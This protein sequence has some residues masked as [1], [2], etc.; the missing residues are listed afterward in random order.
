M[1]KYGVHI[2]YHPGVLVGAVSL[3]RI[4]LVSDEHERTSQLALFDKR[5]ESFLQVFLAEL[6][7]LPLLLRSFDFLWWDQHIVDDLDDSIRS[8]TIFNYD[9]GKTVDLDADEPTVASNINAKR[10]VFQQCRQINLILESVLRSSQK[11]LKDAYMEVALG[12]SGLFGVVS[13]VIGVRVESLVCD[14]MILEQ[15]LQ[16]LLSITTEQE[17]IDSWAKLLKGEIRRR[18]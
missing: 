8:D 3:T 1:L 6:L 13:L 5:F 14:N 17:A 7:A 2:R 10:A 11:R 9:G 4:Q 15:G 16:I 12:D 18:K